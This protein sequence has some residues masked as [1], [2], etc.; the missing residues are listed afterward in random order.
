MKGDIPMVQLLHSRK[1]WLMICD[2]VI[3][4]ATYFITKYANPDAAKDILLVIATVQPVVIAVIV[5]ITVQNVEG[6]R[7]ETATQ[8]MK[9]D[10]SIGYADGVKSVDVGPDYNN[11]N[12][13]VQ[14]SVAKPGGG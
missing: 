10:Y 3:S 9:A 8:Y 4:L 7:K 5:A 2:V 12:G 13:P 14:A 6:I 1:F 11:K